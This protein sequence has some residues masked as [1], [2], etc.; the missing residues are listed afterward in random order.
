M[1]VVLNF[2]KSTKYTSYLLSSG[3]LFSAKSWLDRC[4]VLWSGQLGTM[5]AR[6][7]GLWL[8]RI[9]QRPAMSD[10]SLVKNNLLATIFFF[11]KLVRY[12]INCRV[13]YLVRKEACG[14]RSASKLN[15]FL[16]GCLGVYY[17][18]KT[19]QED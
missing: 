13:I 15:N 3:M 11:A 8:F 5:L 14:N 6:Y 18:S 2:R 9:L 17:T 16:W 10:R 12:K 1:I 4:I 7:Y 19:I